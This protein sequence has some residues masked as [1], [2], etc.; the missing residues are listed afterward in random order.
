MAEWLKKRLGGIR[1]NKTE[2]SPAWDKFHNPQ[3]EKWITISG[4]TLCNVCSVSFVW[5]VWPHVWLCLHTHFN[6]TVCA[7]PQTGHGPLCRRKV[8]S[9]SSRTCFLKSQTRRWQT[10][11]LSGT[12]IC[13]N[14]K[15]LA[16]CYFHHLSL[17]SNICFANANVTVKWSRELFEI[18]PHWDSINNCYIVKGIFFF[19]C[20]CKIDIDEKNRKRIL[21]KFAK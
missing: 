8:S 9:R 21:Y 18:A 3:S 15:R 1:R 20:A 6:C 13:H 19:F 16:E 17:C 14:L 11:N 2:A 4:C 7:C 5:S 12:S 10:E